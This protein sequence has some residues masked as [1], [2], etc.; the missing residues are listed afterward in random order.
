MAE[1]LPILGEP[2]R[3]HVALNHLPLTGLAVA[4]VVLIVALF[5]RNRP[6]VFLGLALILV[7]SASVWPVS[8]TGHGGVRHVRALADKDGKAYLQYHAA[9]AHQWNKLFYATAAAA[10]L[11]ILVAKKRPQFTLSSALVVLAFAAMSLMGG[12]FVA[13]SGARTRHLE[14]RT[15]LP[16]GEGHDDCDHHH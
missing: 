4:A 1:T 9:L 8:A 14:F 13:D 6:A 2:E 3:L 12:W 16:P 7:L 5:L 10:A 11:A 15:G